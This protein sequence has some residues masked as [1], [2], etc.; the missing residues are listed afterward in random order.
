MW[1]YNMIRVMLLSG[2]GAPYVWNSSPASVTGSVG[3]GLTNGYLPYRGTNVSGTLPNNG[4]N[5]YPAGNGSGG[6]VDIYDL[7]DDNFDHSVSALGG[8]PP[9]IGGAEIGAGGYPGGGP[10][11][12][13][14]AGRV[15]A[16]GMGGTV[17]ATHKGKHL[18]NTTT[19]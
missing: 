4:G 7:M 15:S 9:F 17:P 16:T 11:N 6:S 13:T 19:L 8:D 1:G 2:I 3:R 14:I 10:G 18:T 5:A 12:I